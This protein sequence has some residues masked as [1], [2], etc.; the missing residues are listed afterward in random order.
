MV[1]NGTDDISDYR[2]N[3]RARQTKFRRIVWRM[4]R[5]AKLAG[6]RRN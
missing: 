1:P 2:Q 3:R 5:L 4:R 6:R